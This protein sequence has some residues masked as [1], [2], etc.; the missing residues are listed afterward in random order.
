[1]AEAARADRR[2]ADRFVAPRVGI[3]EE[4]AAR[5]HQFVLGRR[6]VGKSTLLRKIESQ[7]QPETNV[8]FVDIETLRSRPY[9]D[10]L[11]ELLI[12]LLTGL[13]E[14]FKPDAWYRIDQRIARATARRKL[15][16]VTAILRRLLAQPQVA[17]RTVRELQSKGTDASV[18]LFGGFRYRGQG[19]KGDVSGRRKKDTEETSVA[20]EEQTKM[21]GLLG[22][23]VL[24]RKDLEAAQEAL[25]EK[26]TLIV[27]DD[28]YHVPYED[29]PEVLAYLHQVVKNLNIFLKVCGVRHRLNPFVEGNPPR[30]MQIPQDASEISLDITLSQFKAAQNFLEAV[31]AGICKPLDVSIDALITEGGRQRLVLG[32]GGVARDYLYLT[33]TALRNANERSENPTRQHNRIGAEDVNEAS[34]ELSSLKQQDLAR[35]A[36]PDADAVRERLSDV[37]KFCL[38]VNGTNV[39]LV[40]GTHLQED[41]W[42]REIQALADLRLLHE[43][44]NLSV[45]T[46][47]YRGRRFVGFTL[48][49]SNWTGARSERIKQLEF[50]TPEGRQEARRARLIYS[51]GASDRPPAT[52]AA[53]GPAAPAAA[54]EDLDGNWV[55]SN[56]F[57]LLGDPT[58]SDDATPVETID[59]TSGSGAADRQDTT[60]P[61]S[62][63][64]GRDA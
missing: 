26:S 56:I 45:Q 29:Q 59:T 8:V 27:L 40:E 52:A 41:D 23:A 44:G 62:T 33:Q 50:W 34:A 15:K 57:Q 43:I 51:P 49:L 24:I 22:A 38:D 55:Q 17:R 60:T 19:A 4:T 54:D 16:K 2:T 18:G 14:R 39:F 53:A 32:S 13:T 64:E 46:G 61:A 42:G 7:E 36:G 63:S 10:V 31:L 28:F 6:G 35:D 58:A 25:G 9:P 11:I 47:R 3:L 20:S 30:G 21:N 12:E 5:R 1:L 37:A 48:D